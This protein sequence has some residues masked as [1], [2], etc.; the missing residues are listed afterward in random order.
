MITFDNR[1]EKSKRK[2]CGWVIRC[3]R[4]GKTSII[5]PGR[6]NCCPVCGPAISGPVR[7]Q[8]ILHAGSMN[9]V[10]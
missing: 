7:I 1:G 8:K 6:R 3:V 10:P 9:A 4:C 5:D 2:G